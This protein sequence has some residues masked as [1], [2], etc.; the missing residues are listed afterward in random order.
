V[1]K[2]NVDVHVVK[3]PDNYEEAPFK[4]SVPNHII[5]YQ[6]SDFNQKE[7]LFKIEDIQPDIII[8]SGWTDKSYL[9]ICKKFRKKIPTVLCMDN[10]WQGTLRQIIASHLS[11]LFFHNRF[12]TIWIPG[13]P[14]YTYAKKLGFNQD[15]IITGMYSGDVDLF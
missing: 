5:L 8:C 3:H 7:L 6:R 2:Y 4:L 12:S 9:S 13:K 11:P 14:Q 10:K 15:N 1:T